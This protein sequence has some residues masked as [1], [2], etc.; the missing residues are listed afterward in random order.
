VEA[1]TE[2]RSAAEVA[3]SY[4]EA[5]A[6]R[7]IERMLEHWHPDGGG[8]IHGM[9]DVKVPDTYHGWFADLFKAFP[10]WKFE[11]L[12]IVADDE[13]A[14]VRWR[15]SGTFTGPVKFEGMTANGAR[16][17]SEGC[18]VLTIR[19]GRIASIYAY[20]NGAEMARQLGALPPT[21][22]LPEKAMLGALNARTAVAKRLKRG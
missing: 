8:Y 12:D 19:D 22:S 3:S 9:I 10:D 6:D 2:P 13:K 7:D 20:T 16:V 4:F 1:A 18:D 17:E 21:G 15:A 14:A 5:V 11:V